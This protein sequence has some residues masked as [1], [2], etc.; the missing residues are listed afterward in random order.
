MADDESKV[1]RGTTL[2]QR[3]HAR[4]ERLLEAGLEIFGTTGYATSTVSGICSAANVS[5]RTFYEL[6]AE[7]VDLIEAIYVRVID[8]IRARIEQLPPPTV[9][10]VERWTK[11]AVRA[12]VGPLLADLRVCRVIEIEVVG[13]SPHIEE[14]R[15]VSTLAI[16]QTLESVQI[17]LAGQAMASPAVRQQVGVFIVGGITETLVAYMRTPAR[18]RQSPDELLEV[19]TAV[20]LRVLVG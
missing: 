15:R 19:V 8:D 14:L 11:D 6:F 3:S 16:A 1:W 20:I 4:R 13:L 12:V 17:A 7:R 9:V 18:E 2:E 5:T 10:G